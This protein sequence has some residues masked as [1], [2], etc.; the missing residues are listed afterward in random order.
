M[1]HWDGRTSQ[2]A[3]LAF[4][5]RYDMILA[6]ARRARELSRGWRARVDGKNSITVTALREIEMGLVGRD[7]LLKPQNIDR[8]ESVPD[9]EK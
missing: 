2:A 7:Y 8:R 5:N 3:V 4:G 9:S 6:G 1:T